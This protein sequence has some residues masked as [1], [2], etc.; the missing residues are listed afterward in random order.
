LRDH[1]VADIVNVNSQEAAPMPTSTILDDEYMSLWYHPETGIVH[2]RIHKYLVQGGFRKLLTA[3]A[4]VL[5]ANRATKYLSDDRTNVVVDPEDVKW[6]DDNWYPR[7]IK[8]GLRHWALVLPSTMVGS[9]QARTILESRRK[10]GLDVEGFDSVETAM[11][12]L[13]TK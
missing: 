2:H 10:Q 12:W 11:A 9:L 7:A 8:A 6:A 1:S 5:E 13:Q 3:S 4:E